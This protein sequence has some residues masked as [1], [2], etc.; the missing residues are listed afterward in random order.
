MSTLM[1]ASHQWAVRPA[2]ERF[3]S[4]IEMQSKLEADRLISRAKVVS[5][6]SLE[7][8]PTDDN[9]GLLVT[10]QAGIPAA[11]TNWAFGQAAN[12]VGA[13]ARYLRELPAPLAADCLN[14]GFQVE[15]DAQDV[16]ILVKANGDLTLQAVT[17]RGGR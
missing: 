3:V 10:G 6:K 13:P 5:S 9:Q 11:P 17:G 8:A 7:F 1:Q 14:Y 16:G 2:E 4:L 12:L 15:R